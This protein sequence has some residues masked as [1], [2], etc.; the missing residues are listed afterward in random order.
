MQPSLDLALL[1]TAPDSNNGLQVFFKTQELAT[2]FLKNP[3]FTLLDLPDLS[4]EP[5]TGNHRSSPVSLVS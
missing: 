3:E 4:T 2:D 1:T 5:Q